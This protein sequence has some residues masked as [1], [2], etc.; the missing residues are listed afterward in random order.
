MGIG[1]IQQYRQNQHELR[2]TCFVGA[3]A[4]IGPKSYGLY[5]VPGFGSI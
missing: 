5:K 2:K 3:D 4:L 1:N